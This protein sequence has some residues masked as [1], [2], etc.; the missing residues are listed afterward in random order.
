MGGGGSKKSAKYPIIN[1]DSLS[2]LFLFLHAIF[3]SYLVLVCFFCF[4]LSPIITDPQPD[5]DSN[6]I[7]ELQSVLSKFPEVLHDFDVYQG[8]GELIRN[9]CSELLHILSLL[10][11]ISLFS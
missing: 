11:S 5:S 7:T 2:L 8:S 9:V 4:P 1:F 3:T 10:C 6:L